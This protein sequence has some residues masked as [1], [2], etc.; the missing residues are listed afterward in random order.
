L[1]NIAESQFLL[2]EGKGRSLEEAVIE[3]REYLLALMGGVPICC[4]KPAAAAAVVKPL[5]EVC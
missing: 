4:I 3:E 5:E 1:K 2:P